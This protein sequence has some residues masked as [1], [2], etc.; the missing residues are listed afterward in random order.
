[1][2]D[3]KLLAVSIAADVGELGVTVVEA[4]RE[5]RN[6]QQRRSIAVA[7]SRRRRRRRKSILLLLLLLQH[8]FNGFFSRTTWVSWLPER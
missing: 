8:P 1:M 5:A 2:I 3:T 4:T 6:R 7:P